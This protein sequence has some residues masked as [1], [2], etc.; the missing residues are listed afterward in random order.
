MTRAP[1]FI[2]S[3]TNALVQELTRLGSSPKERRTCGLTL[4]D[5][6]HLVRAYATQGM[7][8]R[9]LIASESGLGNEEVASLF[10]QCRADRRAVLSDRLFE[11]VSPV[12]T[13]TGLLAVIGIPPMAPDSLSWS[14]GVL[15]DAIQDA[16][17]VGSIL[18]STAAAGIARVAT[19]PGTAD[20]WSPKVL[21]AGMGAHFSLS[22]NTGLALTEIARHVTGHIIVASG[23]GARSIFDVDLRAPSVWVFGAE[24]RGV[25][26]ELRGLANVTVHIPMARGIES[27]N[28]GAAAA[29]CLFEQA[30]QRR[31]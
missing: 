11:R 12:A 2:S 1:K 7:S 27:L 19:A 24:G 28:V 5:G 6:P 23:D 26:P 17:N 30:R 3:A 22:L 20:V 18:R 16:G 8:A 9:T 21:R 10:E 4:I 13:P 31:R 15:L 14:D 25:S 29:I